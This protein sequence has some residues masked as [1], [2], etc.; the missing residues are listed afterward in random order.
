MT[1]RASR[2]NNFQVSTWKPYPLPTG[3]TA[4]LTCPNGHVALL[5]DHTIKPTGEV[6]PSVVCPVDDCTFHDNVFLDGWDSVDKD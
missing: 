6:E 2:S 1:L 4:M 5:D 3:L